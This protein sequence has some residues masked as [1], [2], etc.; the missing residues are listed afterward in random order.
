MVQD[1]FASEPRNDDASGNVIWCL[2][3]QYASRARGD[4]DGLEATEMDR[5]S[6]PT[7]GSDPEMQRPDSDASKGSFVAS[8]QDKETGDGSL[9]RPSEY[10]EWPADFLDDCESRI[11][12]TYRSDFP[13]IMKST[14]A[15][16]TLSVRLRSLADTQGFTSDTGWGCMIRSGQCVL[17]NALLLLRLGRSRFFDGYRG[18]SHRTDAVSVEKRLPTSRRA[19]TPV[20]L[21][22]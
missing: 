18:I 17:A 22:G 7:P 11:W 9:D 16:M 1:F 13:P 14:E 4:T 2:G 19:N 21:R 5:E 10:W 12:M 3:R 15:S 6:A 20:S 8:R